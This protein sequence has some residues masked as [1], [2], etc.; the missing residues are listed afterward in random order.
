[1]IIQHLEWDSKFFNKKIGKID[2]LV[3]PDAEL[4]KNYK[5][6]FKNPGYDL[7]YF[8]VDIA[9]NIYDYISNLKPILVDTQILMNMSIVNYLEKSSY[10][11]LNDK[12]INENCLKSIY[13]IAE[14]ASEVSRFA[15]DPYLKRNARKLYRKMVE[16][17]LNGSFGSGI[18][19]DSE[20]E[21][22]GFIS[23]LL[24]NNLSK[25]LLIAVKK[26]YQNHGIGKVLIYKALQCCLDNNKKGISTIVSAKN[27]GS[28]NFHIRQGFKI[29][30][31]INIYH[32]WV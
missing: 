18:I 5:K 23:L 21:P 13:Q 9:Y 26:E 24:S 27:L 12:N 30:K 29:D 20:E 15:H 3:K 7:I 1:M 4:K 8:F 6:I 25:E 14:E 17:S 11:L 16:N 2:L 19:A 32:L 22:R 28:L 10:Y 31:I